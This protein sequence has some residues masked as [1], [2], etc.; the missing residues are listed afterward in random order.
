MLI[1]LLL[2]ATAVSCNI[3]VFRYALER[4]KADLLEIVI[5][6]SRDLSAEEQQQVAQL[7]G[8]TSEPKGLANSKVVLIRT[9]ANQLP[10]STA[11]EHRTLWNLISQQASGDKPYVVVRGNHARGPFNCWQGSLAQAVGSDLLQSPARAEIAKRLTSGHSIVWLVIL[12]SDAKRNETVL[13]DL[14]ESC[15]QLSRTIELPEGIGLP[16]SE[17]FS[18]VPLLLE[19]STLE[20]KRDD[21]QEAFLLNVA[22]GFQPSAFEGDEPMIIPVFGRGRALEVIPAS[23][24]N[25]RLTE[26]LTL[27]LCG[28]CSCQVKE[29]NPGFDLLL[30]VDW[31]TALFGKGGLRPPPAKKVGEGQVKQ[32]TLLNIPTGRK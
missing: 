20:L 11:P 32:P 10:D 22:R 4:W 17:L 30:S 25:S 9:N 6:H 23:Q 13:D 14:R 15:K 7:G 18:E 12:S 29:Q 26:D 1:F 27:F 5:F 24:F 31:D 28:A 21:P 3:P 2:S 16:G 19:F 8:G